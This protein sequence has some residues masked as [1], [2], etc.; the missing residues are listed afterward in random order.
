MTLAISSSHDHLEGPDTR[1]SCFN[2]K[3]MLK[4]LRAYWRE[5]QSGRY[6]AHK[7]SARYQPHMRRM[8]ERVWRRHS[9]LFMDVDG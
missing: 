5:Q 2:G 4:A 8:P 6:L 7:L 1:S 9:A 3:A